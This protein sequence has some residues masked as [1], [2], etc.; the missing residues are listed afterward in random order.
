MDRTFWRGKRVFLTGHT[1]FKGGWL[2]LWLTDM[3]A[4]VY[5]YALPA[6]TEPNF[7]NVCKIQSRLKN[8]TLAD[9]RDA[10]MLTRALQAAQPHIVLHLAAQPLV[11]QSYVAPV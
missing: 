10:A 7:F 4:E 8:S 1:G 3:G 5:G 9:I 6:P 2:A 11:R